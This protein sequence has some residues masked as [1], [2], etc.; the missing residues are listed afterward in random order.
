MVQEGGRIRHPDSQFNLAILYARGLG[1][2]Q[3]LVASYAWFSAAA[4]NGDEDAGKKRDEV[5]AR[6]SPEKLTQAK[7]AAAAWKPKTPDPAANEVSQPAG[8]WDGAAGAKQ[9]PAAA[10][11]TRAN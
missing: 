5:A 10:R 4:A 11:A 6:L 7:A 2:P 8:G 1:V 9:V 3:D